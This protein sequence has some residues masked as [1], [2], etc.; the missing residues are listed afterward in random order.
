MIGVIVVVT[1]T[2]LNSTLTDGQSFSLNSQNLRPVLMVYIFLTGIIAIS[3]MV[4]PGISGSTILLIFGLYVPILN[5]IKQVLKFNFEYLPSILIFAGGVI[6]G[7]SITVRIV[8]YVLKRFRS[9]TIFCIIGLMIGSMYAVIMGPTSLEIPQPPMSA[10]TFKVL[11]FI[12]GCTLVPLLEIIKDKLK[13]IP[14]NR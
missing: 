12:V 9:Q 13:H 1:M 7:L 14:E 6:V 5:A 11:F 10:S 3:A 2:Y 8:R 4:L